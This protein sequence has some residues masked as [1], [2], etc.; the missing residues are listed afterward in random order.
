MTRFF[1]LFWTGS[2]LAFSI[3]VLRIGA[4][5]AAFGL[6]LSGCLV[7]DQFT[8]EPQPQSS[9]TILAGDP[10]YPIGGVIKF[11]AR[12]A[13]MLSIPLQIRD[14][15]LTEPLRLRWRTKTTEPVQC[16]DLMVPGGSGTLL[17]DTMLMIGAT[18]FDPGSCTRVDL[19]VSAFFTDCM[20]RKDP[21]YFDF[22]TTDNDNDVGLATFLVWEGGSD[23]ISPSA[24]QK[25]VTT[26][27][28][29]DYMLITPE[30]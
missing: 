23:P 26:C 9:P 7:T 12:S 1:G 15:N 13:N 11:D 16:P 8:L 10:M 4:Q 25:I 14:E 19:A 3:S 5:A 18:E 28:Q 24:A 6:G 20:K 29:A 27:P 2:W 21:Q 22:P 17:R 30:M